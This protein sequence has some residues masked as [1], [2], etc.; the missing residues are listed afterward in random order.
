VILIV[1]DCSE[2]SQCMS[3]PVTSLTPYLTF[4][5]RCNS[6]EAAI[7][8]STILQFVL[9]M[10]W[11]RLKDTPSIQKHVLFAQFIPNL[12]AL[13]EIASIT[14]LTFAPGLFDL[15]QAAVPPTIEYFKSLPLDTLRCWAVYVLILGNLTARLN[16]TS[17]VE[18]KAALVSTE[19]FSI[20]TPSSTCLNMLKRLSR[21]ATK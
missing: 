20:T 15:L 5:D 10:A 3:P 14:S 17:K 19:D 2:L 1:D 11:T 9:T 8:A 13:E 18:L 4:P 21:K 12:A 7:M 16:S 6:M